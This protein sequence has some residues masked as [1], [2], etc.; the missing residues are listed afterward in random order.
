MY[1]EYLG[2]LGEISFQRGVRESRVRV[3]TLQ[4]GVAIDRR[5]S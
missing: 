5:G 3:S 4:S 1:L 2:Q